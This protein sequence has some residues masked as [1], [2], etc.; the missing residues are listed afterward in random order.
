MITAFDLL[1]IF[2]VGSDQQPVVEFD[3]PVELPIIL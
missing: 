2:P 1:Q 3:P